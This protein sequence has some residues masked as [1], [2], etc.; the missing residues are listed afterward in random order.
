MTKPLHRRLIAQLEADRARMLAASDAATVDEVRI[1]QSGIA[2]GYLH[3]ITLTLRIHEGPEAAQQYLQ[4]H[5][6]G[7]HLTT[8]NGPTIA[9]AA[10]DDRAYWTTRYDS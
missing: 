3:A 5:A 7:R 6:D 8:H 1:A 4:Q 9:E 10:A 2:A